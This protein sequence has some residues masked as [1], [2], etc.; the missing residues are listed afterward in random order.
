[1]IANK[2]TYNPPRLGLP[3]DYAQR[4]WYE[5]AYLIAFAFELLWIL[6]SATGLPAAAVLLCAGYFTMALFAA[7]LIH[8][9]ATVIDAV[10]NMRIQ[11][12]TDSQAALKALEAVEIHSQVAKICMDS[13]MQL[14]EHNSITLKCVRGH[15]GHEGNERADFLAKKGAEPEGHKRPIKTKTHWAE[16]PWLRQTWMFIDEPSW[17]KTKD[18]TGQKPA[19]MDSGAIHRALPTHATSHHNRVKNN[20]DCRMCGEEENPLPHIMR[21]PNTDSCSNFGATTIEPKEKNSICLIAWMFSITILTFPEAGMVIYMSIQYWWVVDIVVVIIPFF[22][23]LDNSDVLAGDARAKFAHRRASKS[24]FQICAAASGVP[25]LTLV[26][27]NF[28]KG[29][30][31]HFAHHGIRY[32]PLFSSS[33]PPLSGISINPQPFFNLMRIESLYGVTEL[34]C[35]LIRILV[36]VIELVLIQSL[37]TMWKDE[38]LVDKR[39]RDLNMAILPIPAENLPPLNSQYYQNNG[40]DHSADQINSTINRCGYSITELMLLPARCELGAT[41]LNRTV[42]GDTFPTLSSLD[43]PMGRSMEQKVNLK[44]LVKL[45]KT[46]REAYAMLKEVYGNERLSRTQVFE[47]FKR[48]KEG[49]ETAEDS[50]GARMPRAI[51]QKKYFGPQVTLKID[52]VTLKRTRL[53]SV[54]AVKAK[55]KEVLNQLTEADFQHRFQQWK[56]GMERCRDRQ[57][58]HIEDEKV[59]TVIGKKAQSLMDLR[60][61]EDQVAVSEKLGNQLQP[62]MS[63]SITETS[64]AILPNYRSPLNENSVGP[65]LTKC[66]SVDALNEVNKGGHIIRNR[67]GFYAQPIADYGV[68]IYYGPLD[69]PDF[70]IYKKKVDRLT[71]KNSLSNASADDVQKYRDVAL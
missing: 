67:S 3:V 20:P 19:E 21:M 16:V 66:A 18:K 35:W 42:P 14:A 40:Y 11:I 4:T 36:N 2:V 62:W 30:G 41:S 31:C 58:E 59:I 25:F 44:F 49:R 38:E 37:Y 26:G 12:I 7:L 5:I 17:N 24:C 61:L 68:P 47:W 60:I 29:W 15:R 13:L 46:L 10:T 1:M 52:T 28:E 27:N 53:E 64:S 71:S 69:G 45:G 50:G 22:V 9:L 57:G 34:A 8:G 48:F 39:L 23:D 6:E 65:R 32:E 55:A 33:P 56:S 63:Q 51:V 54:E 43:K 70:L